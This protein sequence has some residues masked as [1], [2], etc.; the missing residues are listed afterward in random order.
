MTE[1]SEADLAESDGKNG[2]LEFGVT[3]GW[4]FSA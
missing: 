4:H 3:G 2:R 1:K